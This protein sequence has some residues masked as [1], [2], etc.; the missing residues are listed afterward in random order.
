MF[1]HN[2]VS[3][4]KSQNC[5]YDV[6]DFTVYDVVSSQRFIPLPLIWSYAHGSS[7]CIFMHSGASMWKQHLWRIG[8]C[9]HLLKTSLFVQHCCSVQNWCHCWQNQYM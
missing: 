6:V 7:S 3:L 1:A 8:N 4:V 9:I 2:L 5:F